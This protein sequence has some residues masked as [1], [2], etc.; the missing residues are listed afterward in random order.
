MAI[1]FDG[2][3]Q[4]VDC[5]DINA[6]DG[7]AA[8]TVELWLT[9]DADQ[10]T[11]FA[12]KSLAAATDGWLFQTKS[13]ENQKVLFYFGSGGVIQ[14]VTGDVLTAGALTYLVAVFD[15]AGA[16]NAD[17]LKI[18][19]NAVSQTLTFTGTI[20]ATVPASTASVLFGTWGALTLFLNGKMDDA[21]IYDRAFSA[22]EIEDKYAARGA[23]AIYNSIIGR[24]RMDEGISGAAASGAGSV[25][26][27][28][29][30]NNNG[31]PAGGPTY[32]ES[33]LRKRR[34]VG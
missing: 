33:S 13:L 34:R 25:I 8:L 28:T 21:R 26:D 2:V 32:Q 17:R 24:W 16:T 22:S 9:T 3:N 11:V 15:G 4:Y 27:L 23:D 6:I 1:D 7:V 14:G 19:V 12:S 20:P 31:T 30:N 10:F 29:A 18:Y 5:G